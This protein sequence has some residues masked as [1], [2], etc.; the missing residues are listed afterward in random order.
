MVMMPTQRS[1]LR[2]GCGQLIPEQAHGN[3]RFCSLLCRKLGSLAPTDPVVAE[4]PVAY[5][6]ERCS[7]IGITW[8]SFA[9]RTPAGYWRYYPHALL[10]LPI[11][12]LPPLPSRGLYRVVLFDHRLTVKPDAEF[13][14]ELRELT[15]FCRIVDGR[16]SIG[17]AT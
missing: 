2:P 3:T 15:R 9:W 8:I 1:C 17:G 5:I 4:D 11:S 16:L 7:E 6:N 13:W 10:S 12:E 14:M